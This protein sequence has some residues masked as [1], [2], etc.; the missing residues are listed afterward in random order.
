MKLR[1]SRCGKDLQDI[2]IELKS[3]ATIW[4][5]SENGILKPIENT[6]DETREYLCLDCFDKYAEL[7]DQLNEFD[8]KKYPF[9]LVEVVDDVQF[10]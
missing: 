3:S 1:C 6:S 5:V 10:G 4:K 9:N 8:N 7:L 2:A